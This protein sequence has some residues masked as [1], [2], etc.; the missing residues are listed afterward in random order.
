MLERVLMVL[1]I[2][3]G[4]F[5]LII[6]QCFRL[7]NYLITFKTKGDSFLIGKYLPVRDELTVDD[8]KPKEGEIPKD[9]SGSNKP[10]K[11]IIN[12]FF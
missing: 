4:I 3:I 2:F 10:K 12:N 8:I 7:F 5:Q 9:I 6:L 1:K 11:K